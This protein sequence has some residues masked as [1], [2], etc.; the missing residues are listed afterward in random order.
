MGTDKMDRWNSEELLDRILGSETT[1]LGMTRE[2]LLWRGFLAITH[3]DDLYLSR[4]SHEEDITLLKQYLEVEPVNPDQC[5]P[6]GTPLD[7]CCRVIPTDNKRTLLRLLSGSFKS[8]GMIG[9]SDFVR[10]PGENKKFGRRVP[11]VWLDPGV[12]LL[13]KILPFLRLEVWYSCEGHD[14][15]SSPEIRFMKKEDLRWARVSLPQ[16]LPPGDPT[17]QSWTLKESEGWGGATWYLDSYGCSDDA[18]AVY[19]HFW[20]IQRFCRNVLNS[21]WD[22]YGCYNPI[23]SL[24]FQARNTCGTKWRWGTSDC[25]TDPSTYLFS[26]E[27]AQST[28]ELPRYEEIHKIQKVRCGHLMR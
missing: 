7:V 5:T 16:F 28:F 27:H 6:D 14:R 22:E 23:H 17:I 12:A 3:G 4:G 15:Q 8:T 25:W 18:E 11:V 10:G 24:A 2:I 26:E 21:H 1:P 19:N 20:K 9:S 13:T